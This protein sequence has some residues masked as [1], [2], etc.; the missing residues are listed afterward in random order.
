MNDQESAGKALA[1]GAADKNDEIE[2][3]NVAGLG[4]VQHNLR[5]SEAT[6]IK[7][8]PKQQDAGQDSGVQYLKMDYKMRA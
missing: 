7:A 4:Q 5:T 6:L 1:V 8:Q 3:V 2:K